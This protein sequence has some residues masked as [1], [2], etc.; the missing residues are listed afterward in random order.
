MANVWP[1][2]EYLGDLGDPDVLAGATLHLSEI[3]E[4]DDPVAVS[5]AVEVLAYVQTLKHSNEF[6]DEGSKDVSN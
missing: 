3:S 6:L 4:I 5:N 1:G 2:T